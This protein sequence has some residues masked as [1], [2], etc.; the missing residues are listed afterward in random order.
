MNRPL[1]SNE[2]TLLRNCKSGIPLVVALGLKEEW[3]VDRFHFADH[4]GYCLK[5]WKGGAE[6]IDYQRVA[7][8]I[9]DTLEDHNESG[10][11]NPN[12]NG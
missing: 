3:G 12:P 1:N 6:G 9:Y 11:A 4:F 8:I 10:I 7:G 2:E 5:N